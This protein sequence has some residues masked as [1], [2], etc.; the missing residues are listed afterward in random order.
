MWFFLQV[1]V[2]FIVFYC[3]YRIGWIKGYMTAVSY[4]YKIAE[5]EKK[6]KKVDDLYPK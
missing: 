3:A 4:V 6:K 5:E 2:L 1:F